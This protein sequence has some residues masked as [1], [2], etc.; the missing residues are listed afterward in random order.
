[1]EFVPA[2][3][4]IG[5]AHRVRTV[6]LADSPHLPDGEYSFVD[7]YCIDPAC[8]CRKTMIVVYRDGVHVSTINFGWET[9]AFYRKWM[10]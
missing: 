9:A 7:T 8:D 3:E 1:M 10:R 4:F 5:A 6:E 2:G